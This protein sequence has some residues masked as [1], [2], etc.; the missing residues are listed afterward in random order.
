MANDDWKSRLR[1]AINAAGMSDRRASLKANVGP[2]YVHSILVEGKDPTI[3][4]L[5]ALCEA[6]GASPTFILYGVDVSPEDAEILRLMKA[7]PRKRDAVL[8]LL[9]SRGEG[10]PR[11]E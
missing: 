5:M 11:D 8:E 2:G 1:A 3:G 9:G 7:S 10:T 6:I 4:K